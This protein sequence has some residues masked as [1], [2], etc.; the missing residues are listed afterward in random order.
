M[1][2]IVAAVATTAILS[3][4]GM[5]NVLW[6]NGPLV[7]RPGEGFGGADASRLQTTLGMNTLGGNVNRGSFHRAD[8]F[9]VGPEGWILDQVVTFAYQTGSGPPSTLTGI[10]MQIWDASPAAG[11]NV[12]WGDMTTERFVSTEFSGV[13]RDSESSPG[14]SSRPL[15]EIVGSFDG[16]VLPGGTYWLEIG[17]AGSAASGPWMPAVTIDGQVTT[18]NAL[19]FTASTGVWSD[20]LDSGTETPQGMPFSLVGEVVPAPGA[21]ATFAL[22]G[23]IGLRRRR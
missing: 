20:W 16:L 9:E 14:L 8:S 22:A 11:G 15:M 21:A 13:Y 18:G 23:L 1:N 10:S 19:Q 6:D 4:A 7:N 3:S 12:I 2:K 5:A 17:I